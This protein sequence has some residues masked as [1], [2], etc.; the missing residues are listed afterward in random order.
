MADPANA[1]AT[2][3]RNIEAKTG[4]TIT[5]MGRLIVDSGLKKHGEIRSMLMERLSLGYGDANTVAHL[6]AQAKAPPA[7]PDADPLDSIYAGAKADLRPLHDRVM[8][9]VNAFGAFE[10]APKKSY[11]SLRRKKQFVMVG[12]AT[13]DAD[14]DRPERQGPAGRSTAEGGPAR[15][16]VP[17]QG[18]HR[19]RRRGR[20]GIDRLD[21]RRLR[22]CRLISSPPLIAWRTE[23]P[24]CC[25]TSTPT[26]CS[27]I[28][29]STPTG[30]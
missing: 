10:V 5:Q 23:C 15:G 20:Q 19:L 25:P 4:Q 6:V 22:R 24:A 27:N 29:S 12:P 9:A 11:L 21:A 13:K 18:A 2:Q 14:R 28:R 30:R 26:A 7:S 8:K 3:I 17:V 1:L 16:H